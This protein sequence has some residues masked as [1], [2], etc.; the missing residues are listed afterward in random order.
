MTTNG[1]ALR[2]EHLRVV[3]RETHHEVVGDVSFE[4]EPG[5]VLAFV[6]ESGAGK[7][8]L[9]LALLG[10]A[11]RG[12]QIAAGS[13]WLGA[14]DV[15]AMSPAE[16]AGTRGRVISY[17]PQDP[18]AALNPALRVGT[19]LLEIL[20]AHRFGSSAGERR[21]RV[22]E[23]MEE[24]ALPADVSFLQRYPHE[25]SGGQQRR[26]GLAMAFACRPSVIVLDEPTT[27]LD[28][29]TQSQILSTVGE[30]TA[31]HQTAAL[32]IS[33]D[34]A[35]VGKMARRVAVMY[36]GSL[37]EIG[38]ASDVL[39]AARHPYTRRLIRSMPQLRGWRQLVGIGGQAP[40]PAD[41]PAGCLFAPRCELAQERCTTSMPTLRP[42]ALRHEVRC[43]RAEEVRSRTLTHRAEQARHI[44]APS[45]PV[46]SLVHVSAGYGKQ[47]LLHDIN[48]QVAQHECLALVGASGAGKTTLARSVAGLHAER[49]GQILLD[50]RS[51]ATA[52]RKRSRL[53]RQSIQYIFQNPYGSLNPRRTVGYIVGQPLEVFRRLRGSAARSAVLDM[54][55]VVALP[56]GHAERYPE[57]LSGGERQRVAIARALNC[58]PRVLICDEVTSA[59]DVSVQAGIVELLIRL[60]RDLGLALVFVT[61]DLPLVRSVAQHV[62]VMSRGRIVEYGAVDEVLETPAQQYSQRLLADALSFEAE[63]EDVRS[64]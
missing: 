47:V 62:A 55:D 6:G 45:E 16:I 43:V 19:Q 22:A 32:Y 38:L 28:A 34:L 23:V 4:I 11:R 61:H 27:G 3:T 30:L 26:I 8:T 44:P 29:S 36:A 57:E 13:V 25:L 56:A 21:A 50:G 2:V 41:R 40:T 59:L 12:L 49:S 10:H 64:S 51:L 17:V 9:G 39:R 15:L 7:T 14:S 54:L 53:E 58:N 20:E 46:L 63:L 33:H 42:V 24:V 37:V 48:L 52:A 35:A 31:T 18:V 60:Q 1:P 5:E